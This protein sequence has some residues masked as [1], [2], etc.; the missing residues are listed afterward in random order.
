MTPPPRPD[1]LE[2]MFEA[3][4]LLDDVAALRSRFA[5][6]G[7][8]FF[9]DI[10]PVEALLEVRDDITRILAELGWI[11][12]GEARMA[13]ESVAMPCREGEPRFFDAL[14]RIIRLESFHRLAHDTALGDVMRKALGDTAFPHPLGIMR[15]VFPQNQEITTPPH[16][17]YPNNQ[18]TERLTAA[19]IPLGDCPIEQ[20]PVAILRGSH[21]AGLLP[22]QFH[23][24]AGN[25]SAVLPP[26]LEGRAWVG[27]D[28]RAGDILLFPAL[29][30]H[31]ALENQD[32][33]KMR[34]SVDWRFQLEGESLTEQSLK[35]HF[36]RLT[37]DEIYS[38]WNA[39][40]LKYYWRKKDYEVVPWD[41]SIHDLPPSEYDEAVRAE[42]V[43]E[44]KRQHRFSE[45]MAMWLEHH[46]RVR[47]DARALLFEDVVY[48]YGE[49]NERSNGV[50]HALRRLGIVE[51]D[52]VAVLMDNRPEYLFTLLGSNKLGAIPALLSMDL[53]AGDLSRALTQVEPA[54]II[55]DELGLAS[56]DRVDLDPEGAAEVLV[57]T[58]DDPGEL[59]KGA[60]A[61][62]P[63]VDASDASDPDLKAERSIHAPALYLST[64]GTTGL[65][66]I[67]QLSNPN[68][69][70]SMRNLSETLT[71]CDASDV[72][73]SPGLPFHHWSG[74]LA[75][76]GMSLRAGAAL[77]FRRRFSADE[78][79]DDLRRFAATIFVY[80]GD[81]CR[82]LLERPADDAERSH[83][84][85]MAAGAG[86]DR[87]TWTR[88]KE[89]FGLAEIREFYGA[90]EANVILHNLESIPGML[91]RLLPG[92][93]VV[94]VTA[95]GSEPERGPDGLLVRATEGESGLL[96]FQ[97]N[98]MNGFNSYLDAAQ[99]N[100]A[101]L[102]DPLGDGMNYFD[103]G[104]L[105]RLHPD[106]QVEF[107][108]RL[109][110]S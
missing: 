60:R 4:P 84:L 19:W 66:K 89:R 91:G 82:Q 108:G 14:D 24:G 21:H 39:S 76:F 43:Y 107:E 97:I 92:H 56:L 105:V 74:T 37:W 13:A 81:I 36:G 51:G 40:D 63:L 65:S 50:A 7:Y 77:A 42:M 54:C 55:V 11:R 106:H 49:F 48:T 26:E 73:Y 83:S 99:T 58:A 103:T 20:G 47:A 46:A 64:G 52:A 5:Q 67:V 90:S 30:V 15:L 59:P 85:R 94:R 68:V 71:A 45:K 80:R 35:P 75:A 104:D 6:D 102:T 88:L 72:V 16:Q 61:L 8:L 44:V 69:L 96:V 2:P 9:R 10:M 28:F 101:V 62:G 32:P 1:Q 79:L 100:A 38:G 93:E 78:F 33:S 27:S 109:R 57:W 41:A 12:G 110:S 34:L 31:S 86:L 29:T 22:L 53:E 87:E 98:M 3:N 18:G 23:L 17:D 25:R 95:E 70:R